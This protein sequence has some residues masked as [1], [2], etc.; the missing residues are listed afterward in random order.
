MKKLFRL[1]VLGVVLLQVISCKKDDDKSELIIDDMPPVTSDG[2][3]KAVDASF[4]P[5]AEADG[6]IYK[7]AGVGQDALLALKEAGVNTIRM[8]LWVN[9][10]SGHSNLQEVT[11]FA[12]RVKNMGMQVWLTVHYSDTWA[13]PANQEKP[14]AWAALSMEGLTATVKSYT[15]NVVTTIWPEII[16]IGNETNSGFL[17]PEGNLVDNEAGYLQLV[18]AISATIRQSAPDT[19]IMLHYAGI[20][21]SA[22]WFFNKVKDVDYD[23]I[24]LS[25]YP[26]W[27]GKDLTALRDKM[28]LLGSTYN[29][30]V[31]VAETAYPF[32]LLWND[33]TN[34]VVGQEDQI[35][36]AYPATPQGQK[37]FLLD[38]RTMVDDS[39]HGRG[40]CYWGGE[41]ISWKGNEATD[42]STW[43]N[44]ALWDFDNNALPAMDAFKEKL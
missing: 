43:E 9:P 44:Q 16:Q 36:T 40:F 38:I 5:E 20:G 34:N 2:V 29:K 6:A 12:Q 24:G 30:E 21:E 37:E 31:L 7:K 32:T 28:T 8:R 27:H 11:A 23:Y 17:Y 42:G 33:W 41:W 10:A 22:D 35:I 13:D 26:I 25:F 39:G 3:V 19:K 1:L 18:N 14:A 15:A 4:L